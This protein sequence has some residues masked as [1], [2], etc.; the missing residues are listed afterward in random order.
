L[1]Q[2]VLEISNDPKSSAGQLAEVIKK[3]VSLTAR[4]LKIVNSAY[5]GFHR[6]IGNVNHAIVIL[7]FDEIRNISLAACFMES[8]S[9]SEGSLCDWHDFWVHSLGVA[10]TSRALSR[11]TKKMNPEDAFVVGLLHDF[12]KVILEQHFQAEFHQVLKK[13][14][15]EQRTLHVVCKELMSIDHA[16]I[17]SIVADQWQ[18]PIALK[19]S[20]ELHH[21]PELASSY[22]YGVYIVDLANYFCHRH[23]VGSSG[24]PSPMQP[25]EG[26][27][28]ALGIAEMN[29]EEVW[30]DLA[31]DIQHLKTLL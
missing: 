21:T 26:S 4:M 19:K 27:Q 24:N 16:E 12:G 8:F 7:G 29:L 9:W 15:E 11:L 13:A 1:V 2:S 18:L 17:G 22:D 6:Q 25:F 14:H 31:I 3:D 23:E 5:F 30:N 10:F 28:A 20:I